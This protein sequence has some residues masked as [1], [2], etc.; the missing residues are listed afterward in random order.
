MKLLMLNLANQNNIFSYWYCAFRLW[1]MRKTK[2][3]ATTSNANVFLIC[4]LLISFINQLNCHFWAFGSAKYF[5]LYFTNLSFQWIS[6]SATEIWCK[7][8][9][10]SEDFVLQHTFTVVV[11]FYKWKILKALVVI[12]QLDR[13]SCWFR[14]YVRFLIVELLWREIVTFFLHKTLP[15]HCTAGTQNLHYIDRDKVTLRLILW[16]TTLLISPC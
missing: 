8:Y 3:T 13:I 11:K 1:R 6:T 15:P 16:S 5:F 9:R 2:L 7:L 4:Q 12:Q 10:C 14:K